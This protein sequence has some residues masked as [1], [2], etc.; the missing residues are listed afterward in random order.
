MR[1]CYRSSNIAP[2]NGEVKLGGSISGAEHE[3]MECRAYGG[4]CD[5][6]TRHAM[7]YGWSRAAVG[8]TLRSHQ[9]TNDNTKAG[10]AVWCRV[11][12]CRGAVEWRLSYAHVNTAQ[13]AAHT[14]QLQRGVKQ[15]FSVRCEGWTELR[16]T[17]IRGG[18]MEWPQR[19]QS[20]ARLAESGRK[21]HSTRTAGPSQ[22]TPLRLRSHSFA[23]RTWKPTRSQHGVA[24]HRPPLKRVSST[25]PHTAAEHDANELSSLS[26]ASAHID[27][28]HSRSCGGLGGRAELQSQ[29]NAQA[30]YLSQRSMSA[31]LCAAP[32]SFSAPPLLGLLN[33]TGAALT[34]SSHGGKADSSFF[35]T[36]PTT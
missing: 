17:Y 15:C 29:R 28:T 13:A 21:S 6:H 32:R 19:G 25:R 10:S 7:P 24:R 35:I 18:A 30:R 9:P 23:A 12:R 5:E 8:S 1:N 34:N 33:A 20:T 4:A 3:G 22:P 14:W 31:L 2:L 11:A 27:A 16:A 36:H 26:S